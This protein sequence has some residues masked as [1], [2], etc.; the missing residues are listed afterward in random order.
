MPK[1][2]GILVDVSS[3][4]ND[5]FADEEDLLSGDIVQSIV[6]PEDLLTMSLAEELEA[7]AEDEHDLREINSM[8]NELASIGIEH[9]DNLSYD[10]LSV[11]LSRVESVNP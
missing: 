5:T 2:G 4:V 11:L 8:I 7:G 9:V 10:D 3:T 6:S 1:D